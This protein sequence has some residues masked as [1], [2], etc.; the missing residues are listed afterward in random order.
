MKKGATVQAQEKIMELREVHLQLREENLE[1]QERI[2]E[3]EE[4]LGIKGK[5][6][7]DGSVYWLRGD[8]TTD[9]PYC[10]RCF[11]RDGIPIRLQDYGNSWYCKD[12]KNPFEKRKVTY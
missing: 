1:L 9:G 10:Q 11:D 2:K 7:F 6:T 5:M 8:D 12:C 3:L 4:Q